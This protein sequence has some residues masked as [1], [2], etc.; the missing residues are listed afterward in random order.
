MVHPDARIV[1][2]EGDVI[3]LV[4]QNVQRV[5]PPRTPRGSY[6]IASQHDHVMTM[7]MHRMHLA[8]AV[9]DVYHDDIA[10]THDVHRDV[11]EE[12]SVD[13]PPH[14]RAA[15]YKAGSTTNQIVEPSGGVGRIKAEWGR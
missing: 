3:A 1:C 12:V 14:A 15:F 6:P 7:Q 2:H 10:L 5:H 13:R 4:G 11:R 8:A 9:L